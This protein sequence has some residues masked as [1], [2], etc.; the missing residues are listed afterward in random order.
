MGGGGKS[1]GIPTVAATPPPV[2][3]APAAPEV[4]TEA[5]DAAEKDKVQKMKELERMKKGRSATIL[6]GDDLDD[7]DIKQ[8]TLLGQ[9]QK[10]GE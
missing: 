4:D 8:T 3:S 6:A 2:V 7:A 10:L 9:K 1:T 5:L